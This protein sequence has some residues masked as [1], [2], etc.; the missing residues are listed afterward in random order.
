MSFTSPTNGAKPVFVEPQ[1]T[2]QGSWQDLTGT[3]RRY[4]TSGGYQRSGPKKLALFF[5]FL[6]FLFH[7]GD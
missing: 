2:P 4:N 7:K 6:H 3:F 5:R 1:L